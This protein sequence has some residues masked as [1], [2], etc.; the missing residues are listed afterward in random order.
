MIDAI[1][2][3]GDD[4]MSDRVDSD[5]IGPCDDILAHLPELINAEDGMYNR[6]S[7]DDGASVDSACSNVSYGRQLLG[8][9]NWKCNFFS[10]CLV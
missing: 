2:D 3:T 7:W 6:F 9:V 10:V 8:F 4:R 1:T 5:A